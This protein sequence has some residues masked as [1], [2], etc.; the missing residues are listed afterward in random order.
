MNINSAKTFLIITVIIDSMG[1]G[2]IGPVMPAL[3]KELGNVDVRYMSKSNP[4][5]IDSEDPAGLDDILICLYAI[6]FWAT[7]R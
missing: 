2:L 4:F 7:L 5:G 6:L 3:L 1:I